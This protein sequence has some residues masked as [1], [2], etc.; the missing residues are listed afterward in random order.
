MTELLTFTIDFAFLCKPIWGNASL[1]RFTLV[2]TSF[3]GTA[4]LPKILGETAFPAFRS[5]P[6]TTPLATTVILE[7]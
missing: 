5:P 7:S 4:F 6:T 1:S 2:L 3:G